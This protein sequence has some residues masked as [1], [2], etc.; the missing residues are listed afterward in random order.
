MKFMARALMILSQI[1]GAYG[2]TTYAD[3]TAEIARLRKDIDE[4]IGPAVCSNL[5]NCRIAALGV[6]ACGGPRE[7]LVYSWRS[8]DKA[9]LE[10]KIA[11][12]TLAQEEPQSKDKGAGACTVL[13]QPVAAC[14][15]GRCV[16]PAN[17]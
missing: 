8:T 1:L 12:F 16:L 3:Q 4:L 6:D 7:Y 10:I 17:R 9:A 11:E 2:G 15:N 14:V 13:P 5:V